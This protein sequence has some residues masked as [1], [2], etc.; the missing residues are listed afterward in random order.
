MWSDSPVAEMLRLI[1]RA[2]AGENNVTSRHDAVLPVP[3]QFRVAS[4][5][6][7][8]KYLWG[9]AEHKNDGFLH[10]YKNAPGE[11]NLVVVWDGVPEP[12]DQSLVTNIINVEDR[13]TVFDWLVGVS[14]WAAGL[15]NAQ[16]PTNLAKSA[17]RGET[18]PPEATTANR[19]EANSSE[20]VIP[21]GPTIRAEMTSAKPAGPQVAANLQTPGS[22]AEPASPPA[23]KSLPQLRVFVLD[24]A[25]ANHPSALGCQML[26]SLL[27][28]LPW[29]KVYQPVA[30]HEDEL[31]ADCLLRDLQLCMEGKP[32]LRTLSGTKGSLTDNAKL[33]Q[34]IWSSELTKA[35]TRHSVSNLI[36]PFVLADGLCEKRWTGAT[37]LRANLA[38]S[39]LHS[40]MWKLLRRLGVLSEARMS[41]PEGSPALPL[42]ENKDLFPE[43]RD[44]PFDQL[45]RVRFLLV[46]DQCD[47]GYTKI[48]A[49]ALFGN[50]QDR[51]NGDL[52]L[53]AE[54][55]PHCLVK[56]LY[57]VAKLPP[58][59]QPAANEVDH[60][61]QLLDFYDRT[62]AE[63]H[64]ADEKHPLRQA[65][66][67][68][69][70]FVDARV[71]DARQNATRVPVAIRPTFD[72]EE[73]HVLGD[74]RRRNNGFDIILLDLRLFATDSSAADVGMVEF[75]RHLLLPLLLSNV[76]PSLP[77]IL[78]SSSQ[79]RAVISALCHLPNVVT[80]FSKPL[81][82][83]YADPSGPKD[84][85]DKMLSALREAVRLHETRAAWREIPGCYWSRI[86]SLWVGDRELKVTASITTPQLRKRLKNDYCRYLASQETFDYL[87]V[88]WE[89]LEG[90]LAPEGDEFEFT[91]FRL[92]DRIPNNEAVRVLSKIRN[93]KVHGLS[94]RESVEPLWGHDLWHRRLVI[95]MFILLADFIKASDIPDPRRPWTAGDTE[96]WKNY[97]SHLNATRP[98]D[99]TEFALNAFVEVLGCQDRHRNRGTTGYSFPNVVTDR[100]RTAIGRLM[101]NRM[102]LQPV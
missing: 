83:G 91:K 34:G 92:N 77:I 90:S 97:W 28:K 36:A 8:F 70:T 51:S 20:S 82:S 46:D 65:A 47:L 5:R 100:V 85:V 99:W 26:P 64:F 19:P 29:V 76:D 6:E 73:A 22:P 68:A 31:D 80:T 35:E 38:K 49:T 17:S 60:L 98:P 41:D 63:R 101:E 55:S 18:S 75:W 48:L 96:A 30:R 61:R 24:L 2:T 74:D 39:D 12:E 89:I 58:P 87:S 72:W 1:L 95:L 69:R 52:S 81:V 88:P 33:L 102:R 62:G 3:V 54:K 59:P 78:F 84:Y 37:D 56:E 94:V 4:Y 66:A 44:D 25:S 40:A 14:A 79:Q 50:H 11:Q 9:I 43:E 7:D 93:D 71:P 21:A 57:A 42:V 15:L 23:E 27:Q 53:R 16:K 45:Q 32:P 86:V 13:L 10:V 67:T